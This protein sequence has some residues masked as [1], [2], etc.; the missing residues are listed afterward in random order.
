[1]LLTIPTLSA[2]WDAED[3]PALHCQLCGDLRVIW[4]GLI[5][6]RGE[7]AGET[8]IKRLA[9]EYGAG[10]IQFGELQGCFSVVIV[11]KTAAKVTFFTD[12]SGMNWLFYDGQRVATSFIEL[13]DD[14]GAFSPNVMGAAEFLHTQHIYM[15]RT[16]D[17]SVFKTLPQYFYE[18]NAQGISPKDK[19]LKGLGTPSAYDSLEALF[20]DLHTAIGDVPVE[21][22]LTGGMDSRMLLG[23]ALSKNMPLRTYVSGELTDGKI[24]GQVAKTLGCPHDVS[25]TDGKIAFTDEWIWRQLRNTDAQSGLYLRVNREN[26][27]EIM[28]QNGIDVNLSGAAGELHKDTFWHFDAP[29]YRKKQADFDR[30]YA[31]KICPKPLA[32]SL[33]GDRLKGSAQAYRQMRMKELKAMDA[34]MNTR[35]YDAI[36]MTM[37]QSFS[38]CALNIMARNYRVYAPLME[39]E[40]VKLS[41]LKPRR[42]RWMCMMQRKY[43]T[44]YIPEV[45]KIKTDAGIAPSSDLSDVLGCLAGR[46]GTP[47]K[48]QG[49]K[50]LCR[51]T[52]KPMPKKKQSGMAANDLE[53]IS[54]IDAAQN[55]PVCLRAMDELVKQGFI[56]KGATI[57]AS[58]I[59]LA[60]TLGLLLI[61]YQSKE[62]PG[63]GDWRALEL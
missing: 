29:F 37:L 63:R 16:L 18:S 25:R 38:T 36:R 17:Q 31:M 13:L 40:M 14:R 15:D 46:V 54:Q 56:Q 10:G 50:V 32:D 33:L 59:S 1:M 44:K 27:N 55:T 9:R 47:L 8:A 21:I 4:R 34:G 60:L 62:R 51:I 61:R 28:R 53:R 49:R 23:V 30:L 39:L 24:S 48:H 42:S 20:D 22:D 12:N 6:Y 5:Y 11:D 2:F 3:E 19:G 41:Y 26:K 35:T 58:K 45:R 43:I 52:G 57:P 7:Q